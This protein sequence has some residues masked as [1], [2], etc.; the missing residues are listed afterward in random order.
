MSNCIKDLYDYDLI[1]KCSKCGIVKLK[2]NFHKNKNMNDGLQVHCILCVKQKQK[3]YSNENPDK[4]RKYDLD[5][6]DRLL[7]KQKF[8]TKETRDQIKEYQKKYYLDNRDQIIEY[9]KQYF[10]KNKNKIIESYKKYV[11]SRRESDLNY[12]LACVT[13]DQELIKLSNLKMLERQLKH[14][15][16]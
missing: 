15:I 16:Y 1:K 11:K 2:S 9:K 14:L 12:K 8:Y 5:N 4:K 7:N 6:R 10:Q 13:F 3:Q